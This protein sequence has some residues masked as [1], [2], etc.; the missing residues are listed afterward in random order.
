[1]KNRN[2]FYFDGKSSM[3]FGLYISGDKTFNGPE[4]NISKVSIPGRS[5]DLIFEDGSYKN[6]DYSY[7]CFLAYDLDHKARELRSYLLS[8]QG[9]CR[10]EDD[11]HPEEYR[12]AVFKGPID[13]DVHLLT[14][15]ETTLTFDC[16]PQRYLKSGELE[17][18]MDK[19]KT[20]AMELYNPTYFNAKPLIRVNGNGHGG[21]GYI[22][23]FH[24]DADKGDYSTQMIT[25]DLGTSDEENVITIDSE[26]EQ[27]YLDSLGIVMY[28]NRH[29][30]F[31]NL[32]YPYLAPGINIINVSGDM[33]FSIVPRWYTL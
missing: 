31:E 13:F 18:Y 29:V 23:I 16:K 21:T 17:S 14:A 10:L 5:G 7:Y 8:R 12:E 28:Y 22:N 32:L 33:Q 26:T 24:N 6:Q 4:R 19:K 11:Y 25:V 15:G 9:Y 30:T 3:D 1:M 20:S 2:A 27:T